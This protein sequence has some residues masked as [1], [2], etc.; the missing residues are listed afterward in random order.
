MPDDVFLALANPVRRQLLQL[1]AV[2]PRTAGELAGEFTAGE[3]ALS[4][5]AVAEHLAVL[6]RSGL[7][8][9]EAR[10]RQRVYRLTPE[11]LEEIGE[12]LAPFE[13]YWRRTLRDLALFVEGE[14][15]D[16]EDL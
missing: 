3:R 12:W 10:G 13:R 2:G 14:T 8:A 9:D 7:V 4:R 11:P 6:R 16:E 1:L 5:P 15:D